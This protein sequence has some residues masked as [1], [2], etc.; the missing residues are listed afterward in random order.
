MQ[1]GGFLFPVY[2]QG[3]SERQVFNQYHQPILQ[4]QINILQN[5]DQL[6]EIGF[7][8]QMSNIHQVN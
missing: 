4:Q 2:H 8:G 7:L 6:S 3:G 5:R 1:N